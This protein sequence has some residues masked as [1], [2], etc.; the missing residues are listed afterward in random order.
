M[1][2]IDSIFAWL[3]APFML[4]EPE[5]DPEPEPD[6]SPD[7]PPGPIDK[8]IEM[9]DNRPDEWKRRCDNYYMG[10]WGVY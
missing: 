3:D 10:D 6:L 7:D 9:I 4:A 5:P 8:I 2:L 1:G